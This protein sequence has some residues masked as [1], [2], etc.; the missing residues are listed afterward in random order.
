MTGRE[1]RGTLAQIAD[2]VTTVDLGPRVRARA[3]L[4]RRRRRAAA[5]AVPVAAVLVAAGLLLPSSEPNAAPPAGPRRV[6]TVELSEAAGSP[7]GTA[8][9]LS[10][11]DPG[12]SS[13][14]LVDR[15][16]QAASVTGTGAARP[17]HRTSCRRAGRCCPSAA[18]A[19]SPW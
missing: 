19:R 6:S 8:A 15:H 5:V 13:A 11:V 9:V 10:I 16:G 2:E 1:L 12:S 4:L 18:P 3:Q 7:L 14:W 17:V